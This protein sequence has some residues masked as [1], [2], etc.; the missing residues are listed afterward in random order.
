MTRR[1]R[2]EIPQT[3]S[4]FSL[5]PFLSL[6]AVAMA[7]VVAL[8]SGMAMAL[9]LLAVITCVGVCIAGWR[10][11]SGKPSERRTCLQFDLRTIIRLTVSAA[12][13]LGLAVA[14]SNDDLTNVIGLFPLSILI[15]LSLVFAK[16]IIVKDVVKRPF[17]SVLALVLNVV[18]LGPLVCQ[19]TASFWL[20][21]LFAV[22][23]GATPV[24]SF[25][26]TFTRKYRTTGRVAL[27][28]FGLWIIGMLSPAIW[29]LFETQYPFIDAGPL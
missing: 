8:R 24:V 14:L 26:A 7:I 2:I 23:L 16:E 15:Y 28:C 12:L 25:F 19:V 1:D 6:A 3:R 4:R 20:F 21:V 22:G 18:V 13:W 17:L 9:L 5:F 11:D 27:F 10:D 29:T